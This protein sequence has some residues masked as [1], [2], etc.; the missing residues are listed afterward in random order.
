MSYL[1]IRGTTLLC[2]FIFGKVLIFASTI[3]GNGSSS[4]KLKVFINEKIFDEEISVIKFY[5]LRSEITRTKFGHLT[6]TSFQDLQYFSSKCN[7]L[8]FYIKFKEI[9]ILKDSL[10]I[11]KIIMQEFGSTMGK[12]L[13]LNHF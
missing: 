4:K 3:V 2:I 5:A 7:A 1:S 11:I 13:S 10:K 9:C 6:F 12:K 8:I